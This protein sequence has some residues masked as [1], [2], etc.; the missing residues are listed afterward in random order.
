MGRGQSGAARDSQLQP[1]SGLPGSD[2]EGLS[3]AQRGGNGQRGFPDPMKIRLGL[4][5][6][7]TAVQTDKT[8]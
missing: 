5:D 2:G 1:K 4:G 6:K 3:S 7:M 8:W